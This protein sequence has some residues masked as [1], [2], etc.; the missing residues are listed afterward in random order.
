I[1]KIF[2]ADGDALVLSNNKLLPI[3]KELSHYF[4]QGIRISAYA[5]PQNILYKSHDELCALKNAGLQMI[6]Y[7]V[8]SGDNLV[9]KKICKGASAEQIAEGI[10]RAKKA[11]ITVSTTNLLGIAGKQYSKQHTQSTAKLLS[12]TSPEFISFLMVMF[13]LGEN[14]FRTCFG[15]DYDPLSPLELIQELRETLSDLHVHNSQIRANHASNYLPIKARFPTD[16]L[17]TLQLID[18]VLNNPDTHKIKPEFLR[19]L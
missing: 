10:L 19:G 16:K 4:G 7:G 13:P 17:K 18:E 1:Q 15:N 6:Y 3:L 12:E 14:R 9:L 11:G 5:T 8:E 2:L